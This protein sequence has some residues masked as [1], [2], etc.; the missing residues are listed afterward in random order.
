MQTDFSDEILSIETVTKPE[1]RAVW[2]NPPV[3]NAEKKA[4]AAAEERR[5]REEAQWANVYLLKHILDEATAEYNAY[6][7][8][9][10]EEE[11]WA[12]MD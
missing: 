11:G 6:R 9:V 10:W 7:R 2:V 5:L 12:F 8:A 4:A 1:L 3:L